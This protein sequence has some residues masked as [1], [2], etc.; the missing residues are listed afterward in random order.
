MNNEKHINIIKKRFLHKAHQMSTVQDQ[1]VCSSL[2]EDGPF[3][4][5]WDVMDRETGDFHFLKT[6]DRSIVDTPARMSEFSS[7]VSLMSSFRH[8]M[9]PSLVAFMNDEV[10]FYVIFEKPRQ[11]SLFERIKKF[12]R[13]NESQVRKFVSSLTEIINFLT[14]EIEMR[15]WTLSFET[16]Y[17]NDDGSICQLYPLVKDSYIIR[18]S[19]FAVSRTIS[20]EEIT[21]KK[22]YNEKCMSWF[23]GVT[24]YLISVGCYSFNGKTVE[25]IEN[26]II[27]THP[28]MPDYLSKNLKDLL[29]KLL[30]KNPQM[31]L[32]IDRID[33]NPFILGE[34]ENGFNSM[35][36][37]FSQHIQF[38][39]FSNGGP[40]LTRM[41]GFNGLS[42]VSSLNEDPAL[43]KLSGISNF[44][45]FNAFPSQNDLN[46]YLYDSMG[47]EEASEN[48]SENI[49]D[50]SDPISSDNLN[51][52]SISSFGKLGIGSVPAGMTKS[53]TSSSKFGS[54]CRPQKPSMKHSFSIN[55]MS[56]SGSFLNPNFQM[57]KGSN[58][59]MNSM[60]SSQM[61][62]FGSVSNLSQ[63]AA[64]SQ[65]SQKSVTKSESY[66]RLSTS[67]LKHRHNNDEKVVSF[68]KIP[69]YDKVSIT[70]R[71]FVSPLQ[72]HGVR[73]AVFNG[74]N[75][76]S[77]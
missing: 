60:N 73:R 63:M 42:N 29:S 38:N 36:R 45:N 16:I 46:V 76:D 12:G 54:F 51:G 11:L 40:G 4:G 39:N 48:I 75:P 77:I 21:L 20:P 27:K 62:S 53:I 52:K 24:V 1:F 13:F 56:T 58:V 66:K 17:V 14:E 23:V 37:A 5:C 25:A 61:S 18:S 28:V 8:H 26:S 57:S 19:E 34:P 15:N 30:I 72:A 67:R 49:S 2:V 71:K 68:G 33:G 70:P 35:P 7:E 47:S 55:T 6:I 32:S 44:N 69:S 43:S 59:L 65:N 74:A 31:R 9:L 64:N 41:K 10:S 3:A 50:A 22:V